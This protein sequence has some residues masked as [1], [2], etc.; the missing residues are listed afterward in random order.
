MDGTLL[1]S[2]GLSSEATD[3]GVH[4]ITGRHL[5]EEEN[6]SL[7]GKPV[8]KVLQEWFPDKSHS[9]YEAGI[10]YY[11]SRIGEISSYPGIN[12]LLDNLRSKY[13]MAIVTSTHREQAMEILSKVGILE[14]FSFIIGQDDT[15]MNKPDPEPVLLAMNRLGVSRE[16]C[17]FVG[18]QPYDIIAAHEAGIIAV[19]ATWGT[20]MK[21]VLEVYHP[22]YFLGHP[23]DLIDLLKTLR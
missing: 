11:R 18:D 8:K 13:K 5:T 1:D 21:D 3:F 10:G 20:G 9:I 22:D 16:D 23:A 14:Y 12:K 6:R 4:S 17:I 2:E 7:T 19:A 15:V